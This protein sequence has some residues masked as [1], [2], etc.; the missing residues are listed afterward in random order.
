MFEEITALLRLTWSLV[1]PLLGLNFVR[2]KW[3][4]NKRKTYASFD[5]YKAK[6]VVKGYNQQEY[7]IDTFIPIVKPITVHYIL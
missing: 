1:P 2:G 4:R 6:L 5:H 3:V 7:Y